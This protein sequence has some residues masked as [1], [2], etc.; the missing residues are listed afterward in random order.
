MCIVTN[1]RAPKSELMRIVRLQ[2]GS[3]KVDPKGKERGRGANMK[4]D[5]KV[6]D[7]AIKK[8]LLVKALALEKKLTEEEVQKLRQDFEK[9]IEEKH[10]RQGQKNVT[11]IVDKSKFEKAT[12]F[13]YEDVDKEKKQKRKL[14][15][16]N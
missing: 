3:V 15:M 9:A 12:G 4:M 5:V 6:F 8:G 2:D 10:F 7:Q 1:E 13:K 16:R 14:T 11:L